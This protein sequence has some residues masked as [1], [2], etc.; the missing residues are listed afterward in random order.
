MQSFVLLKSLQLKGIFLI[1]TAL[2]T[3]TY[4]S[5][6]TERNKCFHR[7]R[8]LHKPFGSTGK[9]PPPFKCPPGWPKVCGA[10]QSCKCSVA[11]P[12][13]EHKRF[14][15][16][17]RCNLVGSN[18]RISHHQV[19]WDERLGW[20]LPL[21]T[22]QWENPGKYTR[23]FSNMNWTGQTLLDYTLKKGASRHPFL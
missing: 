1:R 20:C 18:G 17:S 16:V 11:K 13:W 7:G 4:I 3:C 12:D 21:L 23:K 14:C 10:T 8:P 15:W 19:Y 9:M 6:L 5:S 2:T 22:R